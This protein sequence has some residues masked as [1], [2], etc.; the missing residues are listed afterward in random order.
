MRAVRKCFLVR[1]EDGFDVP[2][3][4]SAKRSQSRI[5][6]KLCCRS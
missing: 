2:G 1:K 3:T 4:V 5:A 6:L